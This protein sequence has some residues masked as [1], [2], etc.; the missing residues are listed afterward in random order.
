MSLNSPVRDP[1]IP[2]PLPA[3]PRFLLARACS[4][5]AFQM[6]SVAVGWQVYEL[7]HSAIMLGLIGL[8]QFAPQL[9]LVFVVGHV[10]DR[11]NR[12]RV[13]RTCQ[14]LQAV[15]SLALASA[16]WWGDSAHGNWLTPGLIFLVVALQGAARAFETPALQALLPNIVPTTALPKALARSSATVQAAIILGPAV[17]GLLYLLGAEVVYMTSAALFA[18]ASLAVTS[19]ATPPQ[20]AVREPVTL[21]SM[22]AG[23]RF[24]WHREVVLGAVSLDMFAVLLGGATALLPIYAGDILH[25]GPWGLGMLRA[26][27]AVGAFSMSLWLARH[28]LQRRVGRKLFVGVAVF[29]LATIA[30]GIS[31]SLWVSLPVL[32]VLGASDMISVV[33]RNSL[34][35]LETPDEMRG[36]VGAVNSL[37]IGTSN[38]L[39]EFESG[40]TAAWFG[41][42]PAVVLGGV[43]TLAVVALWMRVFGKLAN[44]DQLA[45]RLAP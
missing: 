27:P 13:A 23:I 7:T 22:L 36:R 45:P 28:P 3:L 30:F 1:E 6:L 40:L 37:F 41:P 5:L 8:A 26:A 29:G 24:I 2:E 17:G 35:Q 20:A 34:V 43:G 32:I 9:A 19:M 33:I 25:T 4:A 15:A 39:G 18:I 31:S 16:S 12:R 10:A 11:Y 44:R 21:H 14:A 38:Q 42:V